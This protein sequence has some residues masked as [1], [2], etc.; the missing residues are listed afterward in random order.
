M[1]V[2][3]TIQVRNNGRSVAGAPERKYRAMKAAAAAEIAASAIMTGSER[4]T[5]TA[6]DNQD[7]T[8]TFTPSTG[9]PVR[10]RVTEVL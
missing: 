8:W 9:A 3:T 10:V 6:V 7:G 2:Y 1:N 5:A 4:A